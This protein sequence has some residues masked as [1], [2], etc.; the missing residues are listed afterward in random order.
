MKLGSREQWPI[1]HLS[2]VWMSNEARKA[3]LRI[4]PRTLKSFQC[5]N[6]IREIDDINN[7]S[8]QVAAHVSN[9]T[10]SADLRDYYNSLR[11]ASE[12]QFLHDE[13]TFGMGWSRSHVC[14]QRLKNFVF[15]K[16]PPHTKLL[17][18]GNYRNIPSGA[19]IHCSALRRMKADS[20]YQPRNLRI[21]DTSKIMNK[22]DLIAQYI[23]QEDDE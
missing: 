22:G 3:G 6:I 19:L 8:S 17:R 14:K 9:G 1:N 15:S 20:T 23:V 5:S 21:S 10:I 18:K 16:I 4:D 7:D 2:L 12:N 11:M 13:L